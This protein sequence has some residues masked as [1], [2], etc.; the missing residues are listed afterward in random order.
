M[1]LLFELPE[2]FGFGL[3]DVFGSEVALDGNSDKSG[4]R[5]R[6]SAEVDEFDITLEQT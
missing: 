6:I 5:E 4:R 1:V 2:D 3:F